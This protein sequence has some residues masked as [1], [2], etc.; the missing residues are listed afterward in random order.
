[1]I[2][3]RYWICEYNFLEKEFQNLTARYECDSYAQE[4][5]FKVVNIKNIENDILKD[6]PNNIYEYILS[7]NEI[8]KF[9]SENQEKI[10]AFKTYLTIIQNYREN[11][12]LESFYENNIK[13]AKWI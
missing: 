12:T 10:F 6:K 2:R 9:K 13:V 3:E 7:H 1:M 4:I 8:Q 11:I 5:L